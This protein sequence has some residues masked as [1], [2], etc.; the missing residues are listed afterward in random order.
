MKY[1]DETGLKSLWKKIKDLVSST[2]DEIR[3]EGTSLDFPT[4]DELIEYLTDDD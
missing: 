4:D 2:A 3:A 1:L